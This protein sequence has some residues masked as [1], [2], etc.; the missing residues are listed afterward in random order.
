MFFIFNIVLLLFLFHENVHSYQSKMTFKTFIN[1]KKL[2]FLDYSDI[3]DVLNNIKISSLHI[4]KL[5][6]YS[7]IEK[8]NGYF[9]KDNINTVNIHQ[10]KQKKID[11]LSNGILKN[12]I[13]A[14][15]MVNVIFSDEG[16]ECVF[17]LRSKNKI[18][19]VYDPLDGSENIDINMPTGTI[20]GCYK[21]NLNFNNT[22]NSINS[23]HNLVCGGYVLY[24]SSINL[25]FFFQNQLYHFEYDDLMKDFICINDNLK[26]P[27]KGNIYSV[28]E[29]KIYNFHKKHKLYLDKIKKENY[30]LRY[31]G[32]LVADLHSILLKG[33]LYMCPKDVN[34]NQSKINLLYK[35]KPISKIIHYAGGIC[36]DEYRNIEFKKIENY[37]QTIPYYFG[38]RENMQD[39]ITF[40]QKIF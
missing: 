40:C 16:N 8:L 10:E 11:I 34:T 4:S 6:S 1:I 37:Q 36:V 28:N 22:L 20:F 27:I 26:M 31:S 13:E 14:Q 7:H 15:R 2:E 35:G 12:N 25:V 21:D 9:E 23:Q 24:S 32:C 30:N 3:L 29:G 17:H 38:S 18:I 5:L 33:G 19:V 39:F